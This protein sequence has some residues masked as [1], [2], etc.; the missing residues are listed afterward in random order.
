MTTTTAAATP[1]DARIALAIRRACIWVTG[2]QL[3][4]VPPGVVLPG[5]LPIVPEPPV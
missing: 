5:W 3:R 4:R 1:A 2:N